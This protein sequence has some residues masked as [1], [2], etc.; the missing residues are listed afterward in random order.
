MKRE[1]YEQELRDSMSMASAYSAA[2][3]GY[4]MQYNEL[5]LLNQELTEYYYI[6]LENYRKKVMDANVQTAGEWDS[7]V[8]DSYDIE[9]IEDLS[10]VVFA[11][12]DSVIVK[13]QEDLVAKM[14]KIS[15]KIEECGENIKAELR[16]QMDNIIENAIGWRK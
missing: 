11:A 5:G 16:F 6:E 12:Y 10:A 1:E 7:D 15:G 8:K 2:R 14:E 4:E 13:M 3:T 9:V